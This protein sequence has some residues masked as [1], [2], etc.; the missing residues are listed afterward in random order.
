[1]DV[2]VG[3]LVIIVG[4]NGGKRSKW[5]QG[6]FRQFL[7]YVVDPWRV[8]GGPLGAFAAP[9]VLLGG[10]FG[11]PGLPEGVPGGSLGALWR[12]HEDPW[13][14]PGGAWGAPF[15]P[16]SPLGHFPSNSGRFWEPFWLHFGITFS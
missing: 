1:M 10:A 16:G 6:C 2:G 3:V 13:A 5:C 12:P 15:D 8:L 14:A 9:W 7:A 11:L 4:L